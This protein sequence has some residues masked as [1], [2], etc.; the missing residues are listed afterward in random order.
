MQK[1]YYARI[2]RRQR[3]G[4]GQ[5]SFAESSFR[6][7]LAMMADS[8]DLVWHDKNAKRT[9]IAADLAWTADGEFV[10]GILGYK[11]S[12]LDKEFDEASWSWAK[13]EEEAR[14]TASDRTLVPFAI[15]AHDDNRFVAFIPTSGLRR[16]GFRRGL[17]KCLQAAVAKQQILGHDWGSRPDR[18]RRPTEGVAGRPSER[19]SADA[20]RPIHQSWT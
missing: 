1:L 11:E 7:E 12:R 19:L 13:G 10:T 8:H 15:D 2:N 9:W 14:D 3:R 20:S 17:E 4:E 18:R 16:G 5:G 6:D